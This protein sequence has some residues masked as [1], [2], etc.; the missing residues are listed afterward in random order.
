MPMLEGLVRTLRR[1]LLD[2]RLLAMVAVV[3]V[4]GAVVAVQYGHGGP[5]GVAG[6]GG[7]T[8]QW[9]TVHYASMDNNLDEYGEW[10]ADL[11][12]LEQVGSTDDS[13]H[14]ALYDG[15]EAGDTVIQYVNEGGVDEY[16]PSTAWPD[17]G[18][19]LDLGDPDTLARF[20]IWAADEYP[21]EKLC[22]VLNNHG[23]GWMGICWDDT[24]ED[25]LMP[26]EVADALHDVKLALGRPVDVVITYACLMASIEF[27]YEIRDGARYLIGSETYSWG[28]ETHG[29][30]YLLGN[31]PFDAI[32]GPVKEDP[33]IAPVDLARHV[34]D[35]FQF[36]GPWTASDMYVYRDYASDTV[37]A[38]DLSMVG[39]L[40]LRVD[41]LGS[42]LRASLTGLGKVLSQR[43]LIDRVIGSQQ[44][45]PE[46]CTQA[47]S[48]Q[49]DWLGLGTFTNYDLVD[50]LDQLEKC[51]IHQ[52]C[53]R[54][55][56]DAVRAAA[57][58]CIVAERHGTDSSQ[59]QHVDAHGMSIYL[60]Y[61]SEEYRASYET[62]AFAMD[63]SWDEFLR[64]IIWM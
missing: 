6:D 45:P 13:V 14:V 39:A 23:G 1:A 41:D 44:A 17:W 62:R 22:L 15:A 46:T 4:L 2:R 12:S 58:A 56:L 50:L 34:V 61:R 24:D 51:D 18:D 3:I 5:G 43:Q 49:P 27:A 40:A 60:P 38:I 32:W 48:G 10:Q 52:L 35:A 36:Y 37:A 11:H 47:F 26:S 42:E 30:E 55:T 19:E 9:L 64:T 57:E 20:V 8:A 53:E 31:Y 59:G 33:S 21:A 28:S 54:A 25:Y 63:T 7:H 29:D 16:S